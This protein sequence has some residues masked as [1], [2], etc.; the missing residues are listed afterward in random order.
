M[1]ILRNSAAKA[2]VADD[3]GLVCE[4]FGKVSSVQPPVQVAPPYMPV[5]PQAGKDTCGLGIKGKGLSPIQKGYHPCC[6][7]RMGFPVDGIQRPS[8]GVFKKLLQERIG[9]TPSEI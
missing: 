7:P 2:V 6:C 3:A 1:Q 5:Q 9:I 8:L 4:P